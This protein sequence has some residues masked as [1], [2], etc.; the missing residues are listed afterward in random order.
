M[1]NQAY[2]DEAQISKGEPQWREVSSPTLFK[3]PHN[4]IGS[5]VSVNKATKQKQ[6]GTGF[7]IAPNLVLTVAHTFLTV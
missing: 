4:L 5:L 2:L 3:Y 7:L 1:S 6:F